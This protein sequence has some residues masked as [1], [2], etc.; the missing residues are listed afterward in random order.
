MIHEENRRNR[1]WIEDENFC[2]N[3]N[4]IDVKEVFICTRYNI[5]FHRFVHAYQFNANVHDN[6]YHPNVYLVRILWINPTSA[7]TKMSINPAPTCTIKLVSPFP[8]LPRPTLWFF[9]NRAFTCTTIGIKFHQSNFYL[10]LQ[11]FVVYHLSVSNLS[12]NHFSSII[13]R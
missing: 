7:Y 12:V 10:H 8:L 2:L 13:C 3:V 11:H 9:I 5:S 4:Y 1:N 6:C